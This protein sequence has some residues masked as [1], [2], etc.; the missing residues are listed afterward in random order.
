MSEIYFLRHG[1]SQ[2]N[3]E[4]RFAN[5]NDG[6]P[7]TD[8]GRRQAEKASAFLRSRAIEILFGIVSY[9]CSSQI[10][11]NQRELWINNRAYEPEVPLDILSSHELSRHSKCVTNCERF[12]RALVFMHLRLFLLSA[13]I[14]QP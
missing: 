10:L 3:V 11:V 6:Y 13:L 9:R 1:Q 2:S 14:N 7:L 5:G 4:N 8:Q 12:K